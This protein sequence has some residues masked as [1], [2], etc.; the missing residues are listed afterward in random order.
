MTILETF[1]ILRIFQFLNGFYPIFR[2][3]FIHFPNLLNHQLKIWR[4]TCILQVLYDKVINYSVYFLLDPIH[5]FSVIFITSID[6]DPFTQARITSVLI[7]TN[8]NTTE[9]FHT[10]CYQNL[11]WYNQ[12]NCYNFQRNNM[13]QS[14]LKLWIFKGF[15]CLIHPF[16]IAF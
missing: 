12:E 13:I 16:F 1:F 5:L 2:W 3:N 4:V 7:K 6:R 10:H 9:R 11:Y 15:V 14:T 8:K